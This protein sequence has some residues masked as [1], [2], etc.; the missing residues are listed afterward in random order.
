MDWKRCRSSCHCPRSPPWR[1]R[2]FPLSGRQSAFC[3]VGWRWGIR[4]GSS[5]MT[6]RLGMEKEKDMT[7]CQSSH[8]TRDKSLAHSW[9][10]TMWRW[11]TAASEYTQ[12]KIAK[13]FGT[14]QNEILRHL[15]T[16]Q[17][18]TE[19]SA[20]RQNYCSCSL[21]MPLLRFVFTRRHNKA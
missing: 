13:F 4:W 20:K 16:F 6:V 8:R 15:L 19:L 14:K 3:P 11:L 7:K 5:G 10:W 1:Y 21:R 17:I 12:I 2:G 9:R 18:K